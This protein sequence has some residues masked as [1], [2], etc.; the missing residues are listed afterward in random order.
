MNKVDEALALIAGMSVVEFAE[1]AGLFPSGR[2]SAP[3]VASAV[4]KRTGYEVV[5]NG[6]PG[7]KHIQLIKYVREETGAG[8]KEA[9][10]SADQARTGKP[11]FVAS[12]LETA[13]RRAAQAT[14]VC[15]GHFVVR[16]A[17]KSA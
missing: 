16:P 15:G 11:L 14:E 12:D 17:L 3:S 10:D 4:K 5:L 1:F 2:V 8:L 7:E 13:V 6:P 9:K